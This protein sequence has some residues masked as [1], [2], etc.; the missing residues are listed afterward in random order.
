[1][2]LSESGEPGTLDL[3]LSTLSARR[4]VHTAASV[5]RAPRLVVLFTT[6][7]GFG[8][9]ANV[10]GYLREIALAASYGSSATTDAFFGAAF[11]PN[12]LYAIIAAGAGAAVLVPVL[13]QYREK[14]DAEARELALTLL[15]L[16][17]LALVVLTLIL[18]LT[19][20]VWIRLLFPGFA[21][22]T[23]RLSVELAYILNPTVIFLSVSAILAGVLNAFG[24]FRAVA[25]A[26]CVGNVVTVV[27]ICLSVNWGG[28]CGAAIGVAIGAFVQLLV[29]AWVA[30]SKTVPY[31]VH[32]NMAH[33]GLR[34]FAGMAAPTMAYLAVAY[35]SLAAERIFASGFSPGA[36]STLSYAMRLFVLPVAIVA[37]S[38]AT[39]LH[40]EFS[41]L[42]SRKE[43]HQLSER[44]GRGVDLTVLMLVPVSLGALVFSHAIVALAYGYGKFS[45]EN[46]GMTASAFAAYSL[47]IIPLALGTLCQRLFYALRVPSMLFIIEC[48]ALIAYLITAPMLGHRYGIPGLALARSCSFLIFG[49]LSLSVALRK[50]T[51]ARLGISLLSQVARCAISAL[52]TTLLWIALASQLHRLGPGTARWAMLLVLAGAAVVGS[53]LYLFI[54]RVLRC[55]GADDAIRGTTG[56]FAEAA[57]RMGLVKRFAS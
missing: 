41:L 35:V 21:P 5:A 44:F 4:E 49:G 9:L 10:L 39:V 30:F 28:I 8:L 32:W 57:G 20:S 1:V 23:S 19:S 34:G 12:T 17:T 24:R 27:A 50:L 14:S 47:G 48:V 18:T 51:S 31:K 15:N 16:T 3:R 42:A 56:R 54:A 25:V 26:P 6:V 43:L 11:I 55:E 13:V 37:G 46:V 7:A 36:L 22:G 52:P 53:T 45:G 40:T 33:P 38:F 29:M 2:N